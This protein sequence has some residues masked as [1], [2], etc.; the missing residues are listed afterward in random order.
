MDV[1]RILGGFGFAGFAEPAIAAQ[2]HGFG[3]SQILEP[4]GTRAGARG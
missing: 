2:I 4:L 3:K 1:D